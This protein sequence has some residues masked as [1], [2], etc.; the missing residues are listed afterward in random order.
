MGEGN[1][2]RIFKRFGKYN[3]EGKG[4][5]TKFVLE[6][7]ANV[8]CLKKTAEPIIKDGRHFKLLEGK[9]VAA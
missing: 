3:T 6:V 9:M 8:V 1:F 2:V 5:P 4:F 7:D